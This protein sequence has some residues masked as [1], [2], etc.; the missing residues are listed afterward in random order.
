MGKM[1]EYE[2]RVLVFPRNVSRGDLCRA[3]AE[4]AEYGHW[5]LSRL[6]LYLGGA[7]KVWL[8]RRIIRVHRTV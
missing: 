5:E 1:M 8:R 7:R 4:E 6:L 3:V 2:Y